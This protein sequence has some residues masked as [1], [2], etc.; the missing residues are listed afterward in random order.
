MFIDHGQDDFQGGLCTV[1]AVSVSMSAGKPTFMICVLE[2][3]GWSANWEIL[4]EEQDKLRAEHGER[5]GHPDP[6]FND[7]GPEGYE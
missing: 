2:R 3:P 7:Y 5:R 6:D 1:S 4:R